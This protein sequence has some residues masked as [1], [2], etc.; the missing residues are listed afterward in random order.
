MKPDEST[1]FEDRLSRV[2]RSGLPA[3]L[4][5]ACRAQARAAAA[6]RPTPPLW[7][8]LRSWF[9]PHPIAWAC[10]AALWCLIFGLHWQA[11]VPIDTYAAT[12]PSIPLMPDPDVLQQLALQR[13]ARAEALRPSPPSL[14]FDLD[15]PRNSQPQ[16]NRLA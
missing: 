7:A 3:D 13:E 6:P 9:W 5:A 8:A 1:P 14:P 11:P 15:R 10:L 2:P 16:T 12:G 4:R